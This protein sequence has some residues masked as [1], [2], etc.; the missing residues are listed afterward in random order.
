MIIN[1]INTIPPETVGVI[2]LIYLLWV[3]IGSKTKECKIYFHKSIKF[4]I[5]RTVIGFTIA[6]GIVKSGSEGGAFWAAGIG[7]LLSLLWYIDSCEVIRLIY[8]AIPLYDDGGK[9]K[10]KKY[11]K[12][13][14]INSR[15]QAG[16]LAILSLSLFFNI[17]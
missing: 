12:R 8:Q 10:A 15:M 7:M 2:L 11:I 14:K 13:R 1:N 6:A 5:I 9:E 3:W 17:I 4:K 16:L